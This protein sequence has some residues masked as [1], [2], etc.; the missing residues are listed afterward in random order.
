[1]TA[2]TWDKALREAEVPMVDPET[3]RQIRELRRLG[4]GKRRIASEV[5]VSVGTVLRYLRRG[6]AA[7]TQV[8]PLARCLDAEQR[9]AAVELLDTTAEGNAVVVAQLLAQQGVEASVRTVQRA[10]SAHRQA[11]R[12]AEAATVR[13]ET[14]PGHQTQIDFG[15]KRV[16]IAGQRVRVFFFVAVLSYSRRLFVKAFLSQRQVWVPENLT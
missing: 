13:F 5:G 15:E 1:M 4:W 7:A 11:R 6:E 10:V 3:V 14:A 12:A 9:A 16:D 8:R 2:R